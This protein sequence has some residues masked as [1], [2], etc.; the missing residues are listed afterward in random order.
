MKR[1]RHWNADSPTDTAIKTARTDSGKQSAPQKT[2]QQKGGVWCPKCKQHHK[3]GSACKTDRIRVDRPPKR[4]AK[5]EKAEQIPGGRAAGRKPSEFDADALAEGTRHEMEHTTDQGER[6]AREIAMDHLAEDPKYY[7]KL[8]EIEKAPAPS[9]DPVARV[10][11]KAGVSTSALGYAAR[12]DGSIRGA[13]KAL[14]GR[15][16]S[17]R[18][19]KDAAPQILWAETDAQKIDAARTLGRLTKAVDQ[20][21]ETP[22]EDAKPPKV[23]TDS[24]QAKESR[25]L[26]HDSRSSAK[27]WHPG[28]EDE[29]DE[30]VEEESNLRRALDELR[31]ANEQL[32]AK[33]L[34][35]GVLHSAMQY[36]FLRSEG[37]DDD[38]IELTKFDHALK[39]RFAAW[40]RKNLRDGLRRL[41]EAGTELRKGLR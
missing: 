19:P 32:E 7:E 29:G 15:W 38:E 25:T 18:L 3:P 1:D 30:A 13:F 34:R 26:T 28:D 24:D 11:Q 6:I 35:D 36:D 17:F 8:R 31:A 23:S 41:D 40:L 5:I 39:Q 37:Y 16:G 27:R 4:P 22:P 14:D 12:D 10:L 9:N 21:E 20:D 33:L 2:P